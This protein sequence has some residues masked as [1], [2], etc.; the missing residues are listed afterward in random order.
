MNWTFNNFTTNMYDFA[1]STLTQ[2]VKDTSIIDNNTPNTHDKTKDLELG[3]YKVKSFTDNSTNIDI[4]NFNYIV[5]GNTGETT[6]A[7]ITTNAKEGDR[8]KMF[9]FNGN[10]TLSKGLNNFRLIGGGDVNI[11]ANK[12]I[13]F[14]YFN[15]QFVE[16]FRSF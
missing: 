1:F 7:S 8:L 15:N 3:R 10:T 6:I 2:I 11:P 13:S 14:I 12:F 16:D 4:T 9:S 5:F